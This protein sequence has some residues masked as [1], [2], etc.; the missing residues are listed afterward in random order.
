VRDLAT[1]EE[2]WLKYGV[3]RDDQESA[4]TRDVLP[5]FAFTSGSRDVIISYGGKIHRLQ[6]STGEASD[7]PFI[8]HVSQGL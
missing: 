8:A 2:K 1:G 4:A 5:G 7:I 6:V 3:Q